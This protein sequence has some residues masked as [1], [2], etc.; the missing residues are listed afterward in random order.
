VG[1]DNS[2][3]KVSQEQLE[4]VKEQLKRKEPIIVLSHIPYP[5]RDE[6]RTHE[7]AAFVRTLLSHRS[8]I[9]GIFTGHNHHSAFSFTG[10]MCQYVSL[11]CFQGAC[12]VVEIEATPP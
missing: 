10:N 4:F 1:I 5:I 8:K 2:T 3:G 6:G 9:V 11:P 7:L 12:F